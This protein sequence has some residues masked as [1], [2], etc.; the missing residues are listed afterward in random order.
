M[1]LINY[2]PFQSILHFDS[3][4]P[5]RSDPR[6]DFYGKGTD[7]KRFSETEKRYAFSSQITNLAERSSPVRAFDMQNNISTTLKDMQK[8]LDLISKYD[9]DID[10]Y[11]EEDVPAAME[12]IKDKSEPNDGKLLAI[13]HF[14]G[15]IFLYAML[16]RCG[17]EGKDSGLAAVTTSSL[18]LLLP[19]ANPAQVLNVPVIPIAT[20][21]AAAHPF[22]AN[23]PYLLSCL[24]PQISASDMLQP[25]LFEKL[26]TK[27][28]DKKI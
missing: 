6:K 25:K 27:N 23:P 5:S 10:N 2:F 14:M 15:G 12:Y 17:Y 24:S 11:L 7:Y 26:V 1:L 3:L 13:G 20:L 18:K 21:L 19:L 28:F 8:Q 9:W 22:A 16:S 4:N